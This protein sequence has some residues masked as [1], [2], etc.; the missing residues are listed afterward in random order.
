[1]EKQLRFTTGLK[2]KGF[3]GF[4]TSLRSYSTQASTRCRFATAGP[5]TIEHST[6]PRLIRDKSARV[7]IFFKR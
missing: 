3:D 1:M 2:T 7:L 5:S 6:V 4:D